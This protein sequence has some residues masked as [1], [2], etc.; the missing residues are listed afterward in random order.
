[1]KSKQKIVSKAVSYKFLIE[2]LLEHVSKH[3]LGVGGS[4]SLRIKDGHRR[5]V[6][7]TKKAKSSWV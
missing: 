2:A 4:K 1:M 7:R 6:A 5:G 3:L